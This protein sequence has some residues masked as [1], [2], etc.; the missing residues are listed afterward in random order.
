MILPTKHEDLEKNVLVLGA[1][2]LREIK[3]QGEVSVEDG[4]QFL[5]NLKSVGVEKYF[6]VILMLHMFDFIEIREE[7]LTLNYPG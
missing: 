7:K 6:D 2:I 4:F 3:K 1:D 5:K